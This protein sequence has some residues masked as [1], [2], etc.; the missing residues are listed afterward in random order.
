MGIVEEETGNLINEGNE[1]VAIVVAS[2]KTGR[3]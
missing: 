3:H 2:I 1:L